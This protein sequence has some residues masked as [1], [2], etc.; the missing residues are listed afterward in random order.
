MSFT[1]SHI[2]KKITNL[3]KITVELSVSAHSGVHEVDAVH[4]WSQKKVNC[5]F[6]LT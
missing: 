2:I 4:K 1:V 5:D 3:E 6:S